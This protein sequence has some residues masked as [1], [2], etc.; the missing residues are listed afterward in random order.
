MSEIGRVVDRILG[1]KDYILEEVKRLLRMPSVSGTGEGIEEVAG[2]LRDWLRD[3][4]GA[5]ATLLRY[6]GHPIVYGELGARKKRTL[7]YYNMYDVQPPGQL[8]LWESPP[9]EARVV[10]GRIVAR[11]AYNTKGALMSG[12]LGIEIMMRELGEPPVNLMFALEGEEELGS[13][14]MPKF[15][16]DR[17]GELEAADAVLFLGP[18]EHV[19]G[20]PTISLGN[21]GIVFIELRCRTSRYEMHGSLARGFYNP[22]AVLSCIAAELIDPLF[23]PKISWLEEKTALPTKADLELLD[24]LVESVPLEKILREHE[25]REPRLRGT[26]WYLAVFFKPNVNIDGFSAGYTGPGTKTVLPEEAVMRIDF[27]LVPNVEPEDAIGGLRA[28]IEKLG[29]QRFVEVNVV[30]CYTWSKIDPRAPVVEVAKDACRDMGLEPY[31]VPITSGSAP[32]YLFTR[33][34]RIPVIDT[35]PGYGARAHAPNEYITVETTWKTAVFVAHLLNRLAL[36]P[37]DV[38]SLG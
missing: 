18:S 11:G 4:L 28:L 22:A 19:A 23:G 27:R 13:P 8:E 16:Q 10:D 35:G 12:L 29:L 38:R 21:K 14:S 36:H 3:R 2:Y 26:D 1:S 25:V 17:R 30:D 34:L 7:L 33:V 9:F 20:K 6:G 37:G 24:Q 15:V 31:L 5:R 32:M